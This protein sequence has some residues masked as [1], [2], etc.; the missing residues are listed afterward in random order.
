MTPSFVLVSSCDILLTRMQALL[1]EGPT[2]LEREL[3][4]TKY[5]CDDSISDLD[6]IPK[7]WGLGFRHV[8]L[9]GETI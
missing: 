8:W 5:T 7:Y 9:V 4:I 2:Q 1:D 6:S 3:I